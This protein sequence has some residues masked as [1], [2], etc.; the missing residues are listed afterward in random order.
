MFWVHRRLSAQE[1]TMRRFRFTIANLLGLVLLLGVGFAALREATELW[2][3]AVFST[4]LG[5]LSVSVLLATHHADRRRAFWL[6]FALFGW[7]YLGASLIP[8]IESRLLTTGALAQLDS[9]VPGRD[10]T[11]R[12]TGSKYVTFSPDGK[13]LPVGRREVIQLWNTATGTLVGGPGGTTENFLRIGHSIVALILAYLGGHLSGWIF[14]N[15]P[16]PKSSGD[17]Q[18]Q[19]T[20]QT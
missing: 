8:P 14:A 10:A 7:L 6:G 4:T 17:S 20:R 12:L 19:P 3:S 1:T 15:G 18:T 9:K 11:V 2:D 5:M 13:S 16:Q